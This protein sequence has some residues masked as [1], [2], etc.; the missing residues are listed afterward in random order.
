SRFWSGTR[1]EYFRLFRAVA[2]AIHQ[3]YPGVMVGGPAV[4]PES[5]AREWIDAF[6]REVGDVADFVS[7]HTYAQSVEQMIADV[8]TY[9]EMF[10]EATGKTGPRVMVTETD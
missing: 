10:R 5:D 4:S 8:R 9:G 7:Y 1:E 6:I 3:R 2:A